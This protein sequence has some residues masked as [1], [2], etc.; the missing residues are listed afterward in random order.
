MSTLAKSAALT[1]TATTLAWCL[2]F[3]SAAQAEPVV[4]CALTSRATCEIS[5]P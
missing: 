4:H 2:T 1:V 3:G 5:E